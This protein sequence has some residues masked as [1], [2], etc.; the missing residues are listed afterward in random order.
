[1][2]NTIRLTGRKQLPVMAFDLT[3]EEIGEQRRAKLSCVDHS[4]L[5]GFPLDAEI[6]LRLSENKFVEVLN[7]GT[8]G[9]PI[10][11]VEVRN[12]SFGA[13]SCQVRIVKSDAVN[14]GLLLGSTKN[15]TYKS[16][17]QTDGIL[18]FQP[19][20]TRPRAWRLDVRDDEN[21]ILYVDERIEDASAWAK[22]DPVFLACVLPY[23]ISEVFGWILETGSEPEDG[24]MEQW[25]RWAESL[26]PNEDMPFKGD[27]K[28]KREWIEK[29]TTTFAA[30][31]R[32]ADQM[33]GSIMNTSEVR[34]GE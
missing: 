12:S 14:S 9:K 32:L 2:R 5:K 19:G 27:A 20:P 13:P 1:M 10:E 21:P 17:G 4:Y 15:W 11:T 30:R 22:S 34:A 7:F 28:T 31:H 33:V 8:I 26:L 23:V 16:D 29:L 25:V 24:W 18:L 6:R 3:I